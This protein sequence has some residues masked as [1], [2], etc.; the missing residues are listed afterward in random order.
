[1]SEG[2]GRFK[3]TREKEILLPYLPDGVKLEQN[4]SPKT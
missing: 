3:D 1:M 2:E 4:F